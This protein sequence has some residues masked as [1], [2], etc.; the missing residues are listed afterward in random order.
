M[1]EE[2]AVATD[3]D[4]AVG[5]ALARLGRRQREAARAAAAAAVARR[6][7]RRLL[8]KDGDGEEVVLCA[9]EPWRRDELERADGAGPGNLAAAPPAARA[10]VGARA[11]EAVAR[12]ER[13]LLDN[14]GGEADAHHALR[15]ARGRRF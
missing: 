2:V 1:D 3:E 8:E 10:G 15:A 4:R 13:L 7:L 11:E 9:R 14:Q 12:A 6:A 5:A